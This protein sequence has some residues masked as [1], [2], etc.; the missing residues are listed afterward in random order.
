MPNLITL[1]GARSGDINFT[2]QYY[3][4]YGSHYTVEPGTTLYASMFRMFWADHNHAS[5][6]NH[7]TLWNLRSEDTAAVIVG[8]YV[9]AV[10]NTGLMIAEA[11]NGNAG[12]VFVGS[13]GASVDNS[14]S[15]YAIAN[16]NATAVEHWDPNV[17]VRNSGLIAAYAANASTGG[18]GGVG[19]ALGVAM[20]N[21]GLLV[22]DAGAS[23]LAEGITAT[24][25]LF[26]RGSPFGD[27]AIVND[28]RIEAMTTAPGQPSYG[29]RAGGISAELFY[30]FNNGLLK[31][32][33]AWSSYGD[34]PPYAPMGIDR[35]T[36]HAD[37][38][39]V[40]RIET[41]RGADSLV[42]NGSIAGDVALGDE[43]DFFDTSG[44]TWTGAADL[45]W[46]DDAFFGSAGG[47][48]VTG[49]R[50]NDQ[51]YGAAGNDLLLGGLG[52]D[53]IVGGTGNDGLYGELGEDH[54]TTLD[55]DRAHGGDGND[56][57]VAG[58]LTFALISGGAGYD[59]LQ[60][61]RATMQLDLGAA[62]VSGRLA[63]IERLALQGSQQIAVRAGDASALAGGA[64]DI[65]GNSSTRVA[66]VGSW[67]EGAVSLRNG[68][69][70]ISYT[71]GDEVIY[72]EASVTVD[73]LGVMPTGFAGLDP[74]AAGAAAP[75][76]GSVPGGALANPVLTI[77]GFNLDRA[78]IVDQGETWRANDASL[79][80]GYS[81]THG[82]V[83]GGLIEMTN[84]STSNLYT[85]IS[86]DVAYIVNSGTIR[87]TAI[88]GSYVNTINIRG[89][90]VNSGTVEATANSG[91]VVAVEVGTP[92]PGSVLDNH[93]LISARSSTGTAIGAQIDYA[94]STGPSP[95]GTNHGRIEAIG[96]T[97]TIALNVLSGG[98]F[99][100]AGTIFA[101]NSAASGVTDATAVQ[102]YNSNF[103]I[104][105]FVNQGIVVGVT[106]IRS[107]RGA[108]DVVNSGRIEGA[109]NLG[110]GTDIVENG[111]VILGRVAL[112]E[113]TDIYLGAAATAGAEVDGGGGS[114]LIVG[115]LSGDRIEGG[116]G[117]DY[118]AGGGGA[119]ILTGGA[120]ADRFVYFAATDSTAAATD[121]I[122][123]F[124]SGIDVIDLRA[125]AP[126]GVTLSVTGGITTVSAQ[127]ANGAVTIRVS[128]TIALTDIATSA[129]SSPLSGTPADD[130]LLG[131]AGSDRIDGG[132][133]VDLMYGG[134]G[135]D[136][137]VVDSQ[138][139][140]V[141]ERV[142]GGVD[143]VMAYGNYLLPDEVENLTLMTAGEAQG[144]SLDNVLRGSAGAD[145]IIG[146]AGNDVLIGGAGADRLLDG[147]GIDRFVYEAVTDSTPTAPD[148]I[149]GFG[150]GEDK[151]DLS[152][153]PVLSIR[154]SR[155]QNTF[156]SYEEVTIETL[157]GVMKIRVNIL[158]IAT[159]G[160][161][162]SDFIVTPLRAYGPASGDFN[163]DGRSDLIWHNPD[164]SCP[165]WLGQPN[166]SFLVNA[167]SGA[168]VIDATWRMA[169]VG[170]FNG[171][172]KDDMLW[173]HSSGEIGEWLG[174]SN[175]P[176]ANNGGAAA[177]PVDNS[178]SVAGVADYNG[179][180]RDDILWRH[181][182]GEVG[183]WLGRPNGGFINNG[184]AA[185][186]A[187]DPSWSV[188]ATADFNGDGRGDVLWRHSSGAFA[189]WQGTATGAL[190]NA[191]PV[192]AGAE[193]SV[194]GTGDFNGDGSADILARAANGAITVW[195]AQQTGQFT[196]FTPTL[197]NRH[198]DWKITGIGDFN[199]DGFDDLLWQ[200]W[201][202]EGGEWLGTGT[203]D[204][205]YNG[206]VPTVAVTWMASSPD[207]H[208][209]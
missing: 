127:T 36:N 104:N 58:D 68:V 71:L 13:G 199:G 21:G 204:F 156:D 186:N 18:S 97:D 60:V 64:L 183:Q 208:L 172:G 42:N 49:N 163:G 165:A 44:G 185:A 84:A 55:G 132:A 98:T 152:S 8:F 17:T 108:D 140:R 73:R 169:G 99:L 93:G 207:I 182:S 52:H 48:V 114:D 88:G 112:G 82:L 123:D 148:I 128:G 143:H 37:G 76:A 72:I 94:S 115:G 28:G 105:R 146:Y 200:N 69:P 38:R 20:F 190:I 122:Q 25:V 164:G 162:M 92:R 12:T 26:G 107:E 29:I 5:F 139:D 144:N 175:G 179:D 7:G 63:G 131:T 10:V 125:L 147:L 90:L 166:G 159:S 47:D 23:I 32:D 78:V 180:G 57:I 145:G 142:A 89:T 134:A 70:S 22:N 81:L 198:F 59:T 15:I 45:G 111:G 33:I 6:S 3:M 86:N 194:V 129:G 158:N 35:L 133:G 187:V 201:S 118:L 170:D 109:I 193:G 149:S 205:S 181:S 62:I 91:R 110:E 14:G 126:T 151:I 87:G 177:N 46:H 150:Y 137:Y 116:A 191:G 124:E 135:N 161:S 121:T 168:N 153:I 27:V 154:W 167:G 9:P 206:P 53:R 4:P 34:H 176:F 75:L 103:A 209:A 100:N 195:L 11:T 202:G 141:I 61:D 65:S 117:N 196:S 56:V 178:W 192:M 54:L 173:R 120:G 184:G 51:L 85:V 77:S 197:Q 160:L 106:A 24:A 19:S 171:D 203:G 43:N 95:I 113:G 1:P 67:V 189:E 2:S 136:V 174:Q 50:G 74:V 83:N 102:L 66:L 157:G 119:D 138:A 39:I 188:V 41:G 30:F 16:G 155:V 96:G 101:G 80:I 31:A 130:V 79:I 40:G